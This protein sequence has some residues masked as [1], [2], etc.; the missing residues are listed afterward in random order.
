MWNYTEAILKDTTEIQIK[1][2]AYREQT[3]QTHLLGCKKKL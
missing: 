1:S 2:T 3:A